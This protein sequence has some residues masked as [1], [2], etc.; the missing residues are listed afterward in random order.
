MG[1]RAGSGGSLVLRREQPGHEPDGPAQ[2]GTHP[3]RHISSSRL[4]TITHTDSRSSR[5]GSALCT[6]RAEIVLLVP[7]VLNEHSARR[8]VPG[9]ARVS[10]SRGSFG[11]RPVVLLCG[12][13]GWAIV[14]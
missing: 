3:G 10:A 1:L 12:H 13:P 4:V 7:T 11:P 2:P 14:S 5:S 6:P 9:S 8:R